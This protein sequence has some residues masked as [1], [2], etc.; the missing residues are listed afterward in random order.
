MKRLS[1]V[2]TLLLILMLV[3]PPLLAWRA[4]AQQGEYGIVSSLFLL[5]VGIIWLLLFSVLARAA[6]AR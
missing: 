4:A 2:E 5:P 3:V 1:T 6:L